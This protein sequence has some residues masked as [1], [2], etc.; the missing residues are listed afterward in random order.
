MASGANFGGSNFNPDNVNLST[1]DPRD[2]VCALD[3][4]GNEYNG[5]LGVRIS[6][7]FVISK[8]NLYY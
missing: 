5:H 8:S 6:A 3:T 7:L 4:S 2:V 1:A